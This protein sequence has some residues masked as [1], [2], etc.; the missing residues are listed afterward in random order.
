[1][2]PSTWGDFN[3]IRKITPDGQVATV[4]ELS[5]AQVSYSYH[6]TVGPVDG[7]L[8][9]S[10]PEQHQILRTISIS[11]SAGTKNNTE[12]V[13]GSGE[14]C[15]PRDKDQCGDGRSAKDAS[16][17][18]I[19]CYVTLSLS[20]VN[21]RW[22]TE[23]SINPLDGSL[24]I[25]DDHLVLRVTPDNRLKVVVGRPLQCPSDPRE[26]SDLATDVYLESPQGIAFAPNGDLYIA[27]NCLEEACSCFDEEH[28]LAATTKLSTISSITV[29][30]NGLLH[31]CDQG[32]LRIRSVT[33]SL[34]QLNDLSEYNIYSPESQEIYVFNRHGQHIATRNT[35]SGKRCVYFLV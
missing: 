31:I 20:Q 26:K 21:L 5:P 23:L 6:L 1:M 14:K 2:A 22:P 33:A 4:V 19:P 8:Y 24:H 12:A 29:S 27:E 28:V 32:N 11:E 9:I 35:I 16:W 7:H 25:L 30:P 34:P 3:L 18:P 10:D 13:V 15:L 17:R